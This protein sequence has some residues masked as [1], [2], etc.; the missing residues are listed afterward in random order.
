MIRYALPLIA[1]ALL[2]GCAAAPLL[3]SAASAVM[4]AA[5]VGKPDVPDAQ[6]PPRNIGLTLAAAPNLNAANDHKPLALVVR[7][8]ALKDPTSFQQAPFDAFTDPTK[9]KAALG[10]DLLNVREITLIP[11]QRYTATEKAVARSAGIRH[12]R[13]VPRSRN[14]AVETDVR[15]GKVGEIR[16]NH[17]PA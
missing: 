14:P 6:K 11:G 5:G 9:E 15:P 12:R 13:A 4:Q 10:A 7:L 8:Y 17:R 2:A 1:C 16:H 3:G